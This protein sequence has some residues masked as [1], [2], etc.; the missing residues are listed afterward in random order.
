MAQQQQQLML[1]AQ[2]QNS[3]FF[4]PPSMMA[5]QFFG[6]PMMPMMVQ[7]PL[8]GPSLPDEAKYGRVDKWRHDV[9]VEGDA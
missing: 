3:M 7:H 8:Q 9:A 4:S 5:P 6:P 1:Q 2:M